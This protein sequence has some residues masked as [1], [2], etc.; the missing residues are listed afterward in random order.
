M[1]TLTAEKID[2]SSETAF[3]STPEPD[4]SAK[5]VSKKFCMDLK[6]GMLYGS[7]DL[8]KCM[9]GIPLEATKLRKG[10]FWANDDI[11]IEVR[12][13]QILGVVGPNGSGKST[14]LRLLAGIFPPD[15]G[16]IRIK[17]TVASLNT[18]GAGFHPHMSGL[19]NIYL[20]AAVLGM[21]KEETED[22]LDSIIE[23]SEMGDFLEAPISTYSS[24]MKTRLGFSIA[25]ALRPDIMFLDEVLAVGDPVFKNKC[26]KKMKELSEKTAIVFVSN[27]IRKITKVCTDIIVLNRGRVVFKAPDVPEGIRFYSSLLGLKETDDGLEDD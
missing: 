16:E 20:N 1:N 6:L 26:Y 10:E 13:G 24:G 14:L 5:G 3:A 4:I 17:G 11:S 23:F 18:L 9:A 7:A 2:E 25:M 22:K 27:S 21:G 12:K 19:E 8:F 15:R